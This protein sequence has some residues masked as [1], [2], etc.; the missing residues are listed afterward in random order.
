MILKEKKCT[1]CKKVK[2]IEEFKELA[3]CSDGRDSWCKSCHSLASILR[4][5]NN[6]EKMREYF[7]NYYKKNSEKRK[8]SSFRWQ[9][10]NIKAYYAAIQHWAKANPLKRQVYQHRCYKKRV[11]T[12]KGKL[13]NSLSS[14]IAHSLK[15]GKANQHWED[16]VGYTLLD[17]M[18]HLE[19]QFK[20]W[21]TW[22][23]YGKD[24][25]T[26]DHKIPISAFNYTKADDLDFRRCWALS[27]LQPMGAIENKIK[28][29]KLIK[30]FQ[31]SLLM[32]CKE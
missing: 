6:P 25:W 5:K 15:N 17:L 20:T 32:G 4:Q 14:A 3:R 29:N 30:H 27:N 19:K 23:N 1:K 26:I 11:S 16:I 12:G 31:P 24:G 18:K 2:L 28:S 22:G 13:N 10:S 7:R 8:A 9:K 21:M